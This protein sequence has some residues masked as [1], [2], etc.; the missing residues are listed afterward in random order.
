MTMND[1]L[2]RFNCFST[3]LRSMQIMQFGMTKGARKLFSLG[4]GVSVLA[5]TGP[6]SPPRYTDIRNFRRQLA[7][8]S[9]SKSTT[10]KPEKV[11]G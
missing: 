8:D 11:Y 6:L 4:N 5:L 7:R 10:A 9:Q 2:F 3:Y 1:R